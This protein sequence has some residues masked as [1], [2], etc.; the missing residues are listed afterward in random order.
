MKS[1]KVLTKI[2]GRE[3]TADLFIDQLPSSVAA[4]LVV[5]LLTG[6]I[7]WGLGYLNEKQA[8]G[9]ICPSW[10]IH[11]LSNLIAY[12]TDWMQHTVVGFL[13]YIGIFVG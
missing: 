8:G 1:R 7:G 6:L 13:S 10:A 2:K 9:S 11:A 3:W 12:V 5:P 4:I